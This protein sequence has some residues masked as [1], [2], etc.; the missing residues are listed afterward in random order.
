MPPPP[1]VLMDVLG[2]VRE[3][4]EV[5]ERTHDVESLRNRQAVQQRGEFAL[6]GIG[7][8]GTGAPE[9][10]RRLA[11]RLDARES[12]VAGLTPQHVAEQTSEQARVLA[13]RQILVGRVLGRVGH[14]QN[15]VDGARG[16]KC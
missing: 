16:R 15:R 4:R 2:D 1:A 9:A 14:G 5:A 13:Q 3:M 10:D 6:D 8:A 12:V 11:D 7:I